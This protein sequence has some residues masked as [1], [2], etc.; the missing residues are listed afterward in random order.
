MNL[1]NKRYTKKQRL[2]CENYQN[3][4]TF[5]P[6]MGDYEL[7]NENFSQAARKSVDWFDGWASDALLR[8]D[9]EQMSI[10]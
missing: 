10:V 9:K 5:E 7:G 4:T 2:W 1:K 3:E 8:C 6:M